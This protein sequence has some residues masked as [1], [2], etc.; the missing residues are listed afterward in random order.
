M[1]EMQNDIL[2]LQQQIKWA[3]D[4]LF[5]FVAS[6]DCN[7]VWMINDTGAASIRGTIVEASSS[8]DFACDTCPAGDPDPIGSILVDGI[9][10]GGIVPVGHSGI[11]PVLLEDGTAS[12]RGYWAKISDTQA[13]RA[14]ITNAAP[15]GGSFP[16]VQQ[17]FEEIGHCLYTVSSGTDV[18]S[19]VF[20]HFN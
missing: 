15:S 11:V 8:T 16:A 17:H 14:D 20:M 12:T 10:D 13:G 1:K 6:Y 2:L 9:A 5:D 4:R 18:L 19:W 3:K 7:V